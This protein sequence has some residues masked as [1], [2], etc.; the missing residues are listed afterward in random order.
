MDLEKSGICPKCSLPKEICIC[1]TL[2]KEDSVIKIR[3]VKRRYGKKVT[4]IEGLDQDTDL[5]NLT[6]KLK[7]KCACGGTVKG[8][9]IELQGDQRSKAKS[10]LLKMGYDRKNIIVQ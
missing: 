9:A 7:S 2:Y 8:D 3:M 10:V 6:N 4:I 5:N 1:Q